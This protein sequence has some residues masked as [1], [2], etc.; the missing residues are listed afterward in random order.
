[1]RFSIELDSWKVYVK[2]V[3]AHPIAAWAVQQARNLAYEL[4]GY[5]W[6]VTSLIRDP[7]TKFAAVF[8]E[9]FRSEGIRISRT[10]SVRLVP[11]SSPSAL[12]GHRP[13]RVPP[14]D[15]DRQPSSTQD[16]D[17]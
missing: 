17:R 3:T 16:G 12:R 10:R 9:A 7:N 13:T 14:S 8:D 5:P 6:P 1:M 4:A 15:A 11:T 2:G